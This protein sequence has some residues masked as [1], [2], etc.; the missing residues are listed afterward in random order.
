MYFT[1]R[2]KIWTNL[3]LMLVMIISPGCIW[4]RGKNQHEYHDADIELYKNAATA[5][6][7]PDVE[8]CGI[9]ELASTGRPR[10]LINREP[11]EYWNLSLEECM[12]MALKN[13]KVLRDL[14]GAVLDAPDSVQT[15][16]DPARGEADPRFGVEA[17][18]SAFDAEWSTQAFFE[19]N[20]KAVN[21]QFFGGGTRLFKQDLLDYSSQLSKQTATGAMLSVR[22]N[23]Q[24]DFN[25][26]PGNATP[27][28]PWG[29][30]FEVE[31]R[32]PILQGA[33]VQFNRIAGPNA[34]PGVYNGVMIARIRTDIALADFQEAVTDLVFSVEYLYWELYSA[35]RKL[36]SIV[37]ARDR[38]LETWRIVNSLKDQVGADEEAQARA[39]YYRLES[40]VQNALNGKL[41]EKAVITAFRGT[42]GVYVNE[43]RLRLL[44]GLPINDGRLIRP[45]NEPVMAKIVFDWNEALIEA[46]MRRTVLRRQKWRIKQRELELIASK[47]FMRPRLDT[48]GRYRWRGLGHDLITHSADSEFDSAFG[49]LLNGDFQEWQA[50]FELSFPAGWRQASAGVRNAELNLAREHALL[51]EQEREVT[52]D[53]SNAFGELERAY[54]AAKLNYNRRLAARQQLAALEAKA[55]GDLR[56]Q[57]RY[58][59]LILDAQRHLAEAD[60][61][62]HGSMAEYM[63][64]VRHVHRSKGSLLDYNEIHLAEGPWPEKAYRN[65]ARRERLRVRSWHLENFVM[66]NPSPVS[67]GPIPQD[68]D[69]T[70]VEPMPAEVVPL[71]ESN[72]SPLP[73]APPSVGPDNDVRSFESARNVNARRSLEEFQKVKYQTAPHQSRTPQ[74]KTRSAVRYIDASVR[75]AS[76]ART[77][78]TPTSPPRSQI[79]PARK[80]DVKAAP[81]SHMPSGRALSDSEAEG[82]RQDTTT[83]RPPT[84]PFLYP[85][86]SAKT[87]SL[88]PVIDHGL[89]DGLGRLQPRVR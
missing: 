61:L 16:Y 22:H 7:Y 41:Q 58:L 53:L 82:V 35:Y 56:T 55:Q 66:Q 2:I 57:T 32:Q 54:I 36:D 4:W 87:Y 40:D 18:L 30:N 8:S 6:E 38:A 20:D 75:P 70:D 71:P 74:P 81:N 77:T 63:L 12:H 83:T 67:N 13:S 45:K 19:K 37:A 14:G 85:D 51:Y 46:L 31:F 29:T 11:T 28:L 23:A 52:N 60:N 68:V 9:D 15:I 62:Y 73:P 78:P 27:N 80:N 48:I 65:A 49:N 64:A 72:S 50:G 69:S 26:A 44:M 47:N 17:A 43:R 33:G 25:N 89:P 5:I 34:T 86:T 10:T 59:D 84:S 88:A 1:K 79:Q 3:L 39:Q 21:N 24:Y 76:A 42:A